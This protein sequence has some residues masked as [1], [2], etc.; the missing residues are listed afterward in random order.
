MNGSKRTILLILASQLENE[1]IL[2]WVNLIS[3]TQ[4]LM[5]VVYPYINWYGQWN[6]WIDGNRSHWIAEKVMWS[7]SLWTGI[8]HLHLTRSFYPHEIDHKP[9]IT[10]S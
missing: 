9:L 6:G 7:L 3:A 10:E 8:T 5:L 1:L 4:K 2:S